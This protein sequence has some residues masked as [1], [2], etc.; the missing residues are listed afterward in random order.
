MGK[1]VTKK[2]VK[3]I[4][5][6]WVAAFRYPAPRGIEDFDF[7]EGVGNL[8]LDNGEWR[9]LV[10]FNVNAVPSLVYLAEMVS[11]DRKLPWRLLKFD[12]GG[13][14]EVD[15]DEYLGF[16]RMEHGDLGMH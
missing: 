8:L 7:V 9:T 5:G 14:R 16:M 11:R 1:S 10:E 15:K 6:L 12:A 4:T 2:A 3:P 13:V